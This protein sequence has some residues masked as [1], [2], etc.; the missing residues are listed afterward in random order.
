VSAEKVVYTIPEVMER[1][2]VSR[3]TVYEL[4]HKRELESI[5][6]GR[7]T[8]RVPVK[9]LDDYITRRLEEEAA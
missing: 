8:R 2:Q 3:W 9:A 1:L 6:I 5:L 7:R 4:I